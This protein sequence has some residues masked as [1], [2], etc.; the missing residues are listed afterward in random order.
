MRTC[1]VTPYLQ[2]YDLVMSA[3][4][5]VWLKQ[6]GEQQ[7]RVSPAAIV[8]VMLTP[9]FA[10]PFAKATGFVLAAPVLVAVFALLVALAEAPSKG[11][12]P[13]PMPA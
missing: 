2:D 11:G 6:A 12:R 10:A 5:A 9:L 8:A 13:L 1:L 7:E 3:F 4:V